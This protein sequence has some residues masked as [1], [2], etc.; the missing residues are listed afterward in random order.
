MG[1]PDPEISVLSSEGDDISS[2]ANQI[3]T[4]RHVL[5]TPAHAE[6]FPSRQRHDILLQL[7]S[8]I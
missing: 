1:D 7:F 3:D 8:L 2:L 5:Q 4:F 6:A